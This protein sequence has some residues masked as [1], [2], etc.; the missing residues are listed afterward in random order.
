MENKGMRNQALIQQIK[1]VIRAEN[2]RMFDRVTYQDGMRKIIDVI[3]GNGK[4]HAQ[5]IKVKDQSGKWHSFSE[6]YERLITDP[7]KMEGEEDG[8]DDEC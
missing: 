2:A 8:Q 7:V 6:V 3:D 4:L 1:E 5:L